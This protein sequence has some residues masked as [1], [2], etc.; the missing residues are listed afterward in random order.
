MI[1]LGA[2]VSHFPVSSVFVLVTGFIA[3]AAIGSVAWF[4]ASRLVGWQ[5]GQRQSGSSDQGGA[6]YDAGIEP[7]E[8]TARRQREG[9]GFKQVPYGDGDSRAKGGY[10]VDR[11]GLINNYAVEPEPY[12]NEP[13]DLKKPQEQAKES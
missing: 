12:I 8:V 5:E 3:A 10:T 13:G 9:S 7:A 6:A 1:L 4:R 11:E 2:D